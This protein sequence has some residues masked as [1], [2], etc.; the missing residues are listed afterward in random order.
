MRSAVHGTTRAYR[1]DA[2]WR[3]LGSFCSTNISTGMMAREFGASIKRADR[4]GREA[5]AESGE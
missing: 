1:D 2:H 4:P 3:D 5:S